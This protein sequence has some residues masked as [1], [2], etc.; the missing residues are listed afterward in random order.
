MHCGFER[1]KCGICR[2]ADSAACGNVFCD[3]G[4][5]CCRECVGRHVSICLLSGQMSAL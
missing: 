3:R 4:L 1:R 5:D 2:V